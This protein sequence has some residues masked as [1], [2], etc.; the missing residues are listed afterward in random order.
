VSRYY[1]VVGNGVLASRDTWE[2]GDD[3]VAV[4]VRKTFHDGTVRHIFL[5]MLFFTEF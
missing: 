3:V 2:S 5:V 4:N 1:E